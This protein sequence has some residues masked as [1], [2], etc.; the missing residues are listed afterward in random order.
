MYDPKVEL[1][2]I[3][4]AIRIANVNP[5]TTAWT[6]YVLYN[7]TMDSD[8][9]DQ[10]LDFYIPMNGRRYLGWYVAFENATDFTMTIEATMEVAEPVLSS[11]VYI[12]KTS[13]WHGVVSFTDT[14]LNCVDT[15]K[16]IHAV[17]FE[18]VK[19]NVTGVKTMVLWVKTMW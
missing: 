18:I 15:A 16:A 1:D 10:T 7:G 2:A 14:A 13:D 5:L 4:K 12:D 8:G 6:P 19:T 9:G 11:C 17:H 3:I